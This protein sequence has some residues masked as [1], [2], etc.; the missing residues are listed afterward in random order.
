MEQLEG[1]VAVVTGAASGIGRAMATRFAAEGMK[2]VL[3][4][5]DEH[6]LD[7]AVHELRAGGADARGH[8]VDVSR[9][10][11]IDDLA[12]AALETFGAVHVVCNNAGVGVGGQ[13]RTLQVADWEW[14]IGVNLWSVVHG[15]RVFLPLLMEQDEGHIVNTASVAGLFAPPFMGPYN[16][17]KSAVVAISETTFGELSMAGSNVGVSVLCPGWVNTRI[18]ESER[19][20]PAH[21]EVA[22]SGDDEAVSA[23][24][25]ELLGSVIASGMDPAEVAAQVVDAVRTKRFYILTHGE[26]TKAVE[27]RMKAVIN[28]EGPPML[29]PQ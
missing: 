8:V 23:G 1:R 20:R 14:A 18:H 2:V 3:A 9:G 22:R 13:L 21:L 7:D 27:A 4:D 29:M 19:A 25:R 16:A 6:A 26:S 24:I 11:D 15:T 10:D 28:G 17:T 12:A 5:I